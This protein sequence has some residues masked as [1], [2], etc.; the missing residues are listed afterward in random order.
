MGIEITDR[1]DSK[2]NSEIS[3][4]EHPGRENAHLLASTARLIFCISRIVLLCLAMLVVLTA[5]TYAYI[6]PGSGALIWQLLLAAF[7]GSV[8]FIRQVRSHIRA[9]F[10]RMWSIMTGKDENKY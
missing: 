3:C 9:L 6:D 7:F 4:G 5:N 1:T 2:N 10:I 8:F